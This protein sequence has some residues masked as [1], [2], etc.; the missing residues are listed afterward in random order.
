V[1]EV[2]EI[3][4]GLRAHAELRERHAANQRL[5][6]KLV[7]QADGLP[8]AQRPPVLEAA[9]QLRAAVAAY[10]EPSRAAARQADLERLALR[11]AR[12]GDAGGGGRF[13]GKA[14]DALCGGR[15]GESGLVLSV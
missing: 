13:A 3:E 12:L 1:D 4:A 9:R 10:L 6:D 7:A 2:K 5:L 8:P 14:G 11:V 15:A